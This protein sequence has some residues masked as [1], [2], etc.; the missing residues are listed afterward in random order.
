MNIKQSFILA[1]FL[2]VFQNI[3]SQD[4]NSSFYTDIE[5]DR[6][7]STKIFLSIENTNFFK[8]DEYFGNLSSGLTY[9]GTF[10][11][12]EIVYQPYPKVRISAGLH[13][14]KYSGLEILSQALPVFSFQY[15]PVTDVHFIMGSLNGGLNHRI[16]E[17]MYAFEENLINNLENGL[18][19]LVNK[20]KIELDVWLNW[21]KFI[22]KTSNS[23]ESILGGV[24]LN[25]FLLGNK[26]ISNLTVN[27]QN[28]ITHKG[29][30]FDD[31]AEKLQ[32]IVNTASG[33]RYTK[34][35]KSNFVNS[36][37]VE[38][39]FLTYNDPSPSPQYAYTMGYSTYS[40]VFLNSKFIGLKLGYWS[41]EYYVSSKGSPLFMSVSEK[42]SSYLLDR[43]EL[44]TAKLAFKKELYKD[45]TFEARFESY[46]DIQQRQL[47]FSY[48]FYLIFNTDFFLKKL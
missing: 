14:L 2:L 40:S 36:L 22:L 43:T 47:E 27:F 28:I 4:F 48:S 41:G 6:N 45:I 16:V 46:M 39:H 32:T 13:L 29:G 21:E 33:F 1:L 7:D 8:N 42:Y 9:I 30:Q 20:K 15:T 18:Q 34:V 10:I 37:G 31:G 25:Y 17:P 19:I 23:Q 26:D 24:N 12:P 44:I 11:R 5:I 38:S 3:Y 35:L